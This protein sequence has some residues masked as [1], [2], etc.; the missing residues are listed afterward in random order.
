MSFSDI[1]PIRFKE[2]L[3]NLLSIYG[4]LRIIG[5]TQLGE[6][7]GNSSC[8]N[9]VFKLRNHP[10]KANRVDTRGSCLHFTFCQL[11]LTH[12]PAQTQSDLEIHLGGIQTSMKGE[13]LKLPPCGFSSIRNP[14]LFR[15]EQET[16]FLATIQLF[17]KC[18]SWYYCHE[19]SMVWW[20][21]SENIFI[22]D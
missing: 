12:M 9:T 21:C 7:K 4:W 13:T 22:V 10:R 1:Q 11:F 17:L 20:I 15:Q 2:S 19:W 14:S 3:K 16:S 18:I 5:D 6:F 8:A